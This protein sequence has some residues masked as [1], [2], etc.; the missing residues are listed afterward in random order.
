LQ[1]RRADYGKQIVVTLARQLT[2]KYGEGL[3][4]EIYA[5]CSNSPS[6]FRIQKLCRRCRH[7]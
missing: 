3:R 2:E 7:N 5:V 6:C 4:K 1:N